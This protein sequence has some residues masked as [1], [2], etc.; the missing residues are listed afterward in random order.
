MR[1]LSLVELEL[2]VGGYGGGGGDG[3]YSYGQTTLYEDAVGDYGGV[4]A[5]SD[6]Q[7]LEGQATSMAIDWR[8]EG[9]VSNGGW[10]VKASVGG[11]S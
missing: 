1:E 5:Q 3:T 8:V 9:T 10:S 4:V 6:A 7:A 2:I 11:K